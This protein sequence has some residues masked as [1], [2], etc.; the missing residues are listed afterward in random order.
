MHK[1]YILSYLSNFGFL[2]SRAHVYLKV[3]KMIA[4][5]IIDLKLLIWLAHKKVSK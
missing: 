4:D 3:K 5:N 2:Y 1:Y